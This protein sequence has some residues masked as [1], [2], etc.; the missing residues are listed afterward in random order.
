VISDKNRTGIEGIA[1]GDADEEKRRHQNAGSAEEGHEPI[2]HKVSGKEQ[3]DRPSHADLF[4]KYAGEPPAAMFP[5][6]R[7]DKSVPVMEKDRPYRSF[8]SETMTP[9]EMAQI[10]LRKNARKPVLR[11]C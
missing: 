3:E 6:L 1:L 2:S 9:L 11:S 7:S 5:M 10:P 4:P 8:Q